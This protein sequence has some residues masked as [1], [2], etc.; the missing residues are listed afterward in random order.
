MVAIENFENSYL[1][2]R[3]LINVVFVLT[4]ERTSQATSHNPAFGMK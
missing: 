3:L 4:D 1:N 2:I